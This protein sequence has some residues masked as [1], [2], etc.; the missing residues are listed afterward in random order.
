MSKRIALAV[1]VG[2]AAL[3][4]AAPPDPVLPYRVFVRPEIKKAFLGNDTIQILQITGTKPTF[5]EGE[6]YRVI[7][8]CRQASLQH[9]TLYV[10]NTAEP[11]PA[12]IAPLAGSSLVT[13]LV[14]LSTNFDVTFIVPRTGMLHVTIYDAD[15]HDPK[16]NSYAGLYLGAVASRP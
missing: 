4:Q 2:L 8:T 15:N 1:V 3:A 16:D 9:A 10:G 6:T 12:A 14:N 7:G 5:Q 11:G 13:N